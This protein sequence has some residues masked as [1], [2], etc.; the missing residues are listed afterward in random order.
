MSP[1]RSCRAGDTVEDYC[2]ACATD[3]FHTVVAADARGAPLRVVCDYCRSEHNYRGGPRL[4]VPGALATGAGSRAP[5]PRPPDDREQ[6]RRRP[7]APD[8]FPLVSD[9]ERTASPVMLPNDPDVDL[10]LL[11]RRVIREE[12]G[13]TPVAPAEKWRGGTFVLR[14]GTPGLQEK[15][16]P[17][18]TFFHKVV[19]LRNRLRTLEQQLN[20]SD[21]PD[22]VKVKLQGY[23]SGCYGSLTSFNILFADADEQFKGASS[24]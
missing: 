24:E 14:P 21:L 10:E 4:T 11:L 9:R 5:A 1:A 23:V 2:R 19:M 17:I 16:W 20:A 8:A 12:S 3:R 18:E 15:S 7:A 6:T 22:D 13:I